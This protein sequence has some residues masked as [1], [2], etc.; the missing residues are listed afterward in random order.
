M[1]P[2]FVIGSDAGADRPFSA[3][4]DAA[5]AAAVLAA[6]FAHARAARPRINIF[7]ILMRAGMVGGASNEALQRGL[8][9]LILKPSLDDIDLLNWQAFDR[10]IELGYEHT[11]KDAGRV[12]IACRACAAVRAPAAPA[13]ERLDR[14]HRGAHALEANRVLRPAG[15]ASARLRARRVYLRAA[16]I[17]SRR[18]GCDPSRSRCG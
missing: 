17:S 12:S 7:Q 11:C 15:P 10:S 18:A 2:G 9:D 16:R 4:Y 1:L 5:E 8:A 6:V 3:D 13:G 14:T